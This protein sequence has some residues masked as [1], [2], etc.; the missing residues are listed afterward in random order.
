MPQRETKSQRYG[1]CAPQDP[2]PDFSS[3]QELAQLDQIMREAIDISAK[4][5]N[6]SKVL[7]EIYQKVSR[8]EEIVSISY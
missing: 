5:Q 7:E 4:F 1:T 8:G 3:F 2:T 6:N